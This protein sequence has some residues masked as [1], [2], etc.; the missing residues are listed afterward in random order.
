[1]ISPLHKIGAKM[2]TDKTSSSSH[3]HSVSLN[4]WL[5]LYFRL[6]V[7]VLLHT[8]ARNDIK[9]PS[10]SHVIVT[11]S[12]QMQRISQIQDVEQAE[13]RSIASGTD[14]LKY[15]MSLE[16]LNLL[17]CHCYLP[18]CIRFDTLKNTAFSCQ[19]FQ[20]GRWANL[21]AYPQAIRTVFSRQSNDFQ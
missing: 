17:S 20:R 7:L 21:R 18:Y 19:L 5:C 3:Q 4:T 16:A 13:N 8:K 1:M 6:S 11:S 10:I 2:G 15:G 14:Y 12:W 9:N